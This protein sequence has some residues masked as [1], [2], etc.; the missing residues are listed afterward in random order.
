[1]STET[2][3]KPEEVEIK[4]RLY[5]EILEQ[6]SAFLNEKIASLEEDKLAIVKANEVGTTYF[7]L[8]IMRKMSKAAKKGVLGGGKD[9]QITLERELEGLEAKL[10]LDF[11]LKVVWAP[12]PSN[13]LS[14]EVRNGVVYVY[15]EDL[16]GAVRTLKHELI[17][18]VL[19]SKLIQPLVSLVNLLI[20]AKEVE[21]Y[22]EKEGIVEALSKIL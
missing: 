6:I 18:Y 13:H 15:E 3:P 21:I 1:M 14:G 5:K 19:T 8:P 4:I 22:R 20:K 12:D 16:E 2:L 10:G 9:F 7:E 17:D 11:G